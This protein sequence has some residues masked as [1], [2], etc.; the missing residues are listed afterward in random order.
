MALA[1]MTDSN[2]DF[3]YQLLDKYDLEMLYMPYYIDGEQYFHDMGRGERAREFFQAQKAGKDLK[4]SMLNPVQ[5]VEYFEPLLKRGDDILFICMSPSLS[6]TYDNAHLA[7]GELL[8]QYPDRRIEIINSRGMSIGM[9]HAT[10]EALAMRDEGRTIDEI[11]QHLNEMIPRQNYIL[12]VDDLSYLRKSGRL[13][14]AAA[15]FGTM[16]DIK[17][18]IDIDYE[19]RLVAKEKVKGR[20]QSLKVI[21]KRIRERIVDPERQTIRIA[22]ADAQ[23]DAE[24]LKQYILELIP[25]LHDITISFLG[26]VIAV[27]VGPGAIGI[28]WMGK[29]RDPQ[30]S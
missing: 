22:Q 4:T 27:H 16:L 30:V 8:A 3:P 18:L 23:E 5:Y 15:F 20:K 29:T 11:A 19:G 2:S 7:K 12:T 25:E 1:I 21:A 9:T 14:G 6:S 10:E 17:P 13:T 28:Q 24:L 26:P